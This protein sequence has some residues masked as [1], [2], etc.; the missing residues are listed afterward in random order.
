MFTV[1]QY[2]GVALLLVAGYAI[3]M[4]LKSK[5]RRFATLRD[6]LKQE[7]ADG[8]DRTQLINQVL[9]DL[10]LSQCPNDIRAIWQGFGLDKE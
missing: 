7:K 10:G 4:G 5:D 6:L 1:K 2:I 9:I 8:I 3:Y